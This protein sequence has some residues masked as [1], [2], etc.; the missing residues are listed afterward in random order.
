[1]SNN[2]HKYYESE[3]ADMISAPKSLWGVFFKMWRCF[4]ETYD[5]PMLER[6]ETAYDE[7][8]ITVAA[9]ALKAIIDDDS[10]ELE[11][12]IDGMNR[13]GWLPVDDE[14]SDFR[15]PWPIVL[16]DA[17]NKINDQMKVLTKGKK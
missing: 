13:V 1:M 5:M 12:I 6:L 14:D 11:Q 2:S 9:I 10:I 8:S 4:S 15:Q 3:T 7:V 17:A 16:V